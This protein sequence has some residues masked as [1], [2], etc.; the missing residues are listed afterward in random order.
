MIHSSKNLVSSQYTEK[1]YTLKVFGYSVRN[2]KYI[3]TL[4]HQRYI[5]S[6]FAVDTLHL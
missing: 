2:N 1:T 4:L 6:L 5:L 3:K